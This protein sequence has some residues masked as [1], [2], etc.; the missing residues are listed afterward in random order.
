MRTDKLIIA[1]LLI[2]VWGVSL[3]AQNPSP[4]AKSIA[5]IRAVLDAQAVAW[6]RGDV[7]AYMDGTRV[8]R[9]RYLSP[10]TE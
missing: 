2:L 1:V 5:A 3:L 4:N 8:L 9:I 10:A 6:N 7:E